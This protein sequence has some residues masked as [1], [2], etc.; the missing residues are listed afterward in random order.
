MRTS[1]LLTLAFLSCTPGAPGQP[2]PH[3]DVTLHDPSVARPMP[4]PLPERPFKVPET[5]TKELS[6]GL[7]IVV[8][9]NDKVPLVNVQLAFNVGSYSAAT[10]GLASLTFDMLDEGAGDL[11]SEDISRELKALAS[12]L[13][14][15]ASTD[16]AQVGITAMRR[17]LEPTLD[18][19]R[20]VVQEP[21]FPEEELSIL[22]VRYLTAIKNA[23][24]DPSGL[25]SRI[26][27]RPLFGDSYRGRI[28]MEEHI[29][30]LGPDDLRAWYSSQ[31]GPSNAILLVGGAITPDEAVALLEPRFGAWAPEGVE[32]P[33]APSPANSPDQEAIYLVD[34]PGAAQSILDVRWVVGERTD[35]DWFPFKLGVD[36]LGGTFM[37]RLNL[38]LREDKGYTYG[39]RCSTI[40]GY[41]PA[42]L[43]CSAS[44]QT[45][46]TGPSL[47]EMRR[48]FQE[49][50]DSRP[51]TDEE[52]SYMQR[53]LVNQY[54]GR[55]E[56]P[57]AQLGEQESIW[58]YDLPEDWADRYL[59][60][61]KGVELESAQK[62]LAERLRAGR[63][64]WVVVG[65]KATILASLEEFGLPIIEFDADGRRIGGNP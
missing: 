18:L 6:N 49:I 42:V 3:A 57:R 27:D 48:E 56:T 60:G 63:P 10:P 2:Q 61:V 19:M 13:R 36:V 12:T 58:R 65:D 40:T 32:R 55:F 44:V 43:S 51:I 20:K 52:L 7:K 8:V 23:R 64:A 4:D 39:A 5:F 30:P 59:P 9:P 16:G 24:N 28:L 25:R 37:S 62:A 33:T 17:N 54:P 45:E 21:T 15:S 11:S 35:D 26:V 38:N 50:L 29:E 1:T 31:V 46:V 22:K 34:K 53:T 41:G 14:A 47:V